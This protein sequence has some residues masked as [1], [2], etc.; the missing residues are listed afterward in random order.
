MPRQLKS[1]HALFVTCRG[2]ELRTLGLPAII[3]VIVI[4]IVLAKWGGVI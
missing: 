3:T 4:T 1:A 2:F